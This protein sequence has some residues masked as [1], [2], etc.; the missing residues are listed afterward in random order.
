MM[1]FYVVMQKRRDGRIYADLHKC[2]PTIFLTPEDAEA[3]RVADAELAPYRQVVELTAVLPR[4]GD[5]A[6]SEEID[7]ARRL[8]ADRSDDNIEV[9]DNALASR[10]MPGEGLWVQAWVWLPPVDSVEG[11]DE[12]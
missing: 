6:T 11:S 7:R 12:T 5:C 10:G 9:D 2:L 4:S 8:Y 1:T 3:A